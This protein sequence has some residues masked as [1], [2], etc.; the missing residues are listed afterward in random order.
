MN[1]DNECEKCT[2]FAICKIREYPFMDKIVCLFKNK[3]CS[4]KEVKKNGI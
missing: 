1:I 4:Y 3:D 2:H